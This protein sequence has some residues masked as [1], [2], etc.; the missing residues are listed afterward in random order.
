MQCSVSP[1]SLYERG[2]RGRSSVGPSGKGFMGHILKTRFS[3]SKMPMDWKDLG[4]ELS[5]QTQISLSKYRES[6]TEMCTEHG[7]VPLGAVDLW[8]SP[9]GGG[10]VGALRSFQCL[11]NLA[12]E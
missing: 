7:P 3:S 11:L 5:I 9:S 8:G 2:S 12:I 10:P 4:L 1:S 6:K